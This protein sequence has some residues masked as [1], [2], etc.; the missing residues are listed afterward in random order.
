MELLLRDPVDHDDNVLVWDFGG[1]DYLYMTIREDGVES[2]VRIT[3][4][5]A[6]DLAEFLLEAIEK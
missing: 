2:D 5:Q 3:K 1:S 6:K 4:Q